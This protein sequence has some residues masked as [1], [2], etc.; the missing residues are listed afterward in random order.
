M[1]RS[2]GPVSVLA[3]E[4]EA[5][6][7]D[8]SA[9]WLGELLLVGDTDPQDD[10]LSTMR[11]PTTNHLTNLPK[12]NIYKTPRYKYLVFLRY[13][14]GI[15]VLFIYKIFKYK[16]TILLRLQAAVFPLTHLN[17][18][19]LSPNGRKLFLVLLK[20]RIN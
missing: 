11:N 18:K 19:E 14:T 6:G 4:A 17:Q 9:A 16:C 13:Y 15:N 5:D 10:M 8:D 12:M 20:Q 2:T 7:A 1:T 3:T